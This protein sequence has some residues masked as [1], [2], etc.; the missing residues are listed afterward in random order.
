[1]VTTGLRPGEAFGLK[2]ADIKGDYITIRRAINATGQI[3]NG[4]N[5]NARRTIKMNSF[6]KSI[7][8]N[9]IG[10]GLAGEWLFPNP[11]GDHVWPSTAYDH[12]CMTKE[13]YSIEGRVTPYSMRHTFYSI[14]KQNVPDNLVKSYM[15]HSE[16]MDTHGAYNKPIDGEMEIAAGLLDGAFKFLD[17]FEK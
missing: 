2:K 4:K 15:G 6:A 3:T 5:A 9:Q 8:E 7:Y 17:M 12:W 14:S 1:M 13:K 10:R 11:E 16:D